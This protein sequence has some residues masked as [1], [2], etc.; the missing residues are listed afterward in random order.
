MEPLSCT[1]WDF[2]SLRLCGIILHC[3]YLFI[4]SEKK[5]S[6]ESDYFPGVSRIIA[7]DIEQMEPEFPVASDPQPLT[8]SMEE[9][10]RGCFEFFWNE[11]V[12]DETLPT[13]GLTSGDY[14]GIH[15]YVP[16]AIESQ[17]FYF[18][19]IIL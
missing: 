10:L 3:V 15:R 13:H 7:A 5:I 19:I 12:R 9:E 4:L 18:P 17:G 1:S 11:W 8:E 6:E 2:V 14:I 16:L